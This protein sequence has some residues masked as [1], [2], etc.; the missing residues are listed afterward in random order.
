MSVRADSTYVTLNHFDNA[1]V[2]ILNNYTKE[3]RDIVKEETEEAAGYCVEKIKE[4][5]STRL[6]HPGNYPSTWNYRKSYEDFFDVRYTCYSEKYQLVHLLE[7]GH[8]L[9]YF[10]KD[11][12]MYVQA[13]PH[14]RPAARDTEARLVERIKARL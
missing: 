11:T 9:W 12:G 2:D 4:N 7:Y 10:G 14:I 6:K 1:V 3:V 13:F 5:A 8:R